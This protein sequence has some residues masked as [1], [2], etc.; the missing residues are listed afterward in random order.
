[1]VREN[2][3][4]DRIDPTFRKHMKRIA[5]I[6]LNKGLAKLIPQELSIREQ[7]NLLIKTE[8][9]QMSLKELETKPKR[10]K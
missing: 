4:T 7:T 2:T 9:F 10:R 1:M 6:R 3:Q 5:K 8:G